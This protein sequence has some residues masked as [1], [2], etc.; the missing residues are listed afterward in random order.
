MLRKAF[1]LIILINALFSLHAKEDKPELEIN[2][3]V[4]SWGAPGD[5]ILMI[6]T[7]DGP[8]ELKLDNLYRGE[9][10]NYRGGNPVE[11][12][13]LVEDQNGQQTREVVA[14][15]DIGHLYRKPLLLFFEY[16]K[17]ENNSQKSSGYMVIPVE[18]DINGFGNGA[19]RFLNLS[20][21]TVNIRLGKETFSLPSLKIKTITP[22]AKPF[23]R[24]VFEL[25]S[26][27]DG[28]DR[29]GYSSLFFMEPQSRQLVFISK[30]Q[31]E[32]R[33]QWDVKVLPQRGK[34]E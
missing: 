29:L 9:L 32:L 8:V 31:S 13:R 27:I 6:D 22:Q 2:F 3:H 1:L 23:E 14:T 4:L 7:I 21:E 16:D 25:S 34:L 24:M 20:R 5:D 28:V 10:Y 11:V 19:F 18:D 17:G 30:K 33:S 12:Y 15:V 26:E